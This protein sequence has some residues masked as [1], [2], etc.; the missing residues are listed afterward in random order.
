MPPI[1]FEINLDRI[2]AVYIYIYISL[3]TIVIFNIYLLNKQVSL[4]D[5]II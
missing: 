1:C 2:I 3:K 5:G 4:F